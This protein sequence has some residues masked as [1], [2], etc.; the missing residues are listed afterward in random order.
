MASDVD[1]PGIEETGSWAKAQEINRQQVKLVKQAANE[2]DI[3][4]RVGNQQYL[5]EGSTFFHLDVC[6]EFYA[7][8]KPFH[9]SEHPE[10][11]ELTNCW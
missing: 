2:L 3:K 4:I 8:G 10:V 11:W 5:N 7:P 9:N 1:T 6:P